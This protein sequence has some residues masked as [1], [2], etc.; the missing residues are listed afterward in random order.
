MQIIG[1]LLCI[2]VAGYLLFYGIFAMYVG[3]LFNNLWTKLL[4]LGVLS[5]GVFLLLYVYESISIDIAFK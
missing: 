2:A 1:L 4:A 3:V 5:A